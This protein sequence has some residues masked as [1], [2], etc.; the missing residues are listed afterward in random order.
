MSIDFNT[1]PHEGI[2]SL[3]PYQPGKSVSEL[4]GEKGLSQIIK[5]ASNENPLGCSP[6]AIAAL[7]QISAQSIASYPSVAHHELVSKLAQQ[8]KVEPNQ[9]LLSNGS[10]SLFTLLMH[11]FALHT[12]KDIVTHA[13]AF[14]AY[15]IQA[16]VLQIPTHQVA[17][18]SHWQVNITQLIKASTK[19][20]G[21]IF[22][23]NPNNPTG[24][25]IAPKHIIT[26]LNHIPASTLLVLDEAYYEYAAAQ[27]NYN[28]LPLLAEYKNLVITRTFSKIY[29]LAGLRLGYMVAH[30]EIIAILK[31]I[32]LP[33]AVNQAALVAA[34]EAID[35]LTFMQKSL[36]V[37]HEGM[38]QL[39]KGF[40]AL[41]LAY[42]PSVT[43]FLTF[44][45]KGDSRSL[46][47]YFLDRGIILRGLHPYQLPRHVRVTI[48]TAEQNHLFL[49]VL[50]Q[51]YQQHAPN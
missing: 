31:K 40:D 15:E 22:L 8:L 5:M 3:V 17:V 28:F 4:R 23:A 27:L 1:L 45:S 9:L 19:D 26:L 37:N 39:I 50:Q 16:K 20:T 24:V 41:N 33:F 34:S 12:N 7:S 38:Q 6:R 10:D 47:H 43:N 51:Y 29:G 36:Q 14:S 25:F 30:P 18:D 21:L 2:Q 32:Q 49:T 11:C 48:G 35:D 42:I 13:Y 44:D 46:D